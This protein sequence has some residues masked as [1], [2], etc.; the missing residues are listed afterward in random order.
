[1]NV[2]L[3][4][5]YP[6]PIGGVSIHIERLAG[7]L[8]QTGHRV[9]VYD[10][11][12]RKKAGDSNIT[13][14]SSSRE[15]FRILLKADVV[16]FHELR[17]DRS[18]E[19]ILAGA[20]GKRLILTIH[21]ERTMAFY[22]QAGRLEQLKIKIYLNLFN[23]IV[24]VSKYEKENIKPLLICKGKTVAIPA[25]LFPLD[26]GR[27]VDKRVLNFIEKDFFTICA[28]G[29]IDL[30]VKPEIYG[31]DMLIELMHYLIHEIHYKA[32]LIF[33]LMGTKEWGSRERGYYQYL[34][35]KI[36]EYHLDDYILLHKSFHEEF[37]PIC[38]ISDL[39]IRPTFTDGYS[40]SLAEA[41]F[42]G[43]P[44]LA[45][46]AGDRPGGILLFQKGNQEELNS[47]TKAVID[48]YE[49][50]KQRVIRMKQNDF[51][52]EVTELYR[53]KLS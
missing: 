5:V 28:N 19:C 38:R 6:P 8:V 25:F 14:L 2:I 21:N 26:V 45:S 40:L 1:M 13:F 9:F 24:C 16:H 37:F 30:S 39:L 29:R 15:F 33:Y 46:D 53:G 11:S 52:R 17:T 31:I 7:F 42:C 4:G 41:V 20:L 3:V 48:S 32:K 50:Y 18:W 12:G 27:P 36:K 10:T 44:V 35:S 23:K 51:S 22:R 34:T 49:F 47:K 43:T